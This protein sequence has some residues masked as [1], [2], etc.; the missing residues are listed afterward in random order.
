MAKNEQVAIQLINLWIYLLFFLL[1]LCSSTAAAVVDS[2]SQSHS[3]FKWKMRNNLFHRNN[4]CVWSVCF[5]L[6]KQRQFT[7]WLMFL[8]WSEANIYQSRATDRRNEWVKRSTSSSS[9]SI[10]F[11][12]KY[13]SRVHFPLQVVFV[14]LLLLTLVVFLALVRAVS[15]IAIDMLWTSTETNDIGSVFSP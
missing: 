4:I 12:C 15:P 1:L 13:R 7:V 5:F 11:V 8:C 2:C 14:S 3:H 10:C 9:E 6:L